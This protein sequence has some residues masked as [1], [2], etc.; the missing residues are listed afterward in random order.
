M[1]AL[2]SG[3][4][5]DECAERV[6]RAYEPG[7]DRRGTWIDDLPRSAFVARIAE[8]VAKFDAVARG[9]ARGGRA[10]TEF[11]E[12]LRA[13]PADGPHVASVVAR[14]RAVAENPTRPFYAHPFI[15]RWLVEAAARGSLEAFDAL[16]A[17]ARAGRAWWSERESWFRVLDPARVDALLDAYRPPL[18]PWKIQGLLGQLTSVRADDTASLHR[19]FAPRVLRAAANPVALGLLQRFVRPEDEHALVCRALDEHAKRMDPA[20][21]ERLLSLAATLSSEPLA[22]KCLQRYLV[23]TNPT[24]WSAEDVARATVRLSDEPR[25]LRALARGAAKSEIDPWLLP[26]RARIQWLATLDPATVSGATPGL[27]GRVRVASLGLVRPGHP[28][29]RDARAALTHAFSALVR[30][31]LWSS[32]RRALQE[33]EPFANTEDLE[34]LVPSLRRSPAEVLLW[35]ELAG[36]LAE[37]RSP[38]LSQAIEGF[39]ACLV[40]TRDPSVEWPR[41]LLAR[42]AG[43]RSAIARAFSIAGARGVDANWLRVAKAMGWLDELVDAFS[44]AN[45]RVSA[46][47]TLLFLRWDLLDSAQRAR[48]RPLLDV[49][50]ATRFND[51]ERERLATMLPAYDSATLARA[52]STYAVRDAPGS[53]PPTLSPALLRVIGGARGVAAI[54]ERLEQELDRAL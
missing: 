26:R 39:M 46:G 32:E 11:V 7:G 45:D 2:L 3:S 29:D 48:L 47:R 54:A 30:H 37:R 31:R 24:R 42:L 22:H 44:I 43:D 4:R 23:H 52:L 21:G 18:V 53:A 27:W 14:V 20:W 36:T 12:A 13:V 8:F 33:L 28:E 9:C 17:L 19:F 5:A 16:L 40:D 25:A 15:A 51:S 6:L 35:S 49:L 50:L 10:P 1:S 38:A 41:A 34:A